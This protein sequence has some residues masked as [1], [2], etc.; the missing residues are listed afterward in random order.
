MPRGKK[1][2]V[3]VIYGPGGQIIKHKYHYNHRNVTKEKVADKQ[4]DPNERRY[5]TFEE[6]KVKDER[7]SS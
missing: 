1:Q 2:K 3:I 4:Y 6:V 7:H 5:V